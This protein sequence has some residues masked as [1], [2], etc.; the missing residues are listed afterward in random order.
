VVRIRKRIVTEEQT[1][2]V[3][4]RRE[5][6]VVERRPATAADQIGEREAASSSFDR[7]FTL[8]A[9]EVTVQTR[10]VPTERAGLGGAHGGGPGDQ[11]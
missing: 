3:T 2:T 1:I 5:E 11:H 4:T 10:T 6:L 9:E 7:L 8:S